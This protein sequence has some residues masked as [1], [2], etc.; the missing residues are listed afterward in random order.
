VSGKEAILAARNA[1]KKDIQMDVHRASVSLAG[2]RTWRQSKG[3]GDK[4]EFDSPSEASTYLLLCPFLSFLSFFSFFLYSFF[5]IIVSSFFHCVSSFSSFVLSFCFIFLFFLV[6]FGF[7]SSLLS[8]YLVVILIFPQPRS[9][10]SASLCFLSALLGLG[11][12]SLLAQ[13]LQGCDQTR[14]QKATL[15]Q[16]HVKLM[17]VW[18]NTYTYHF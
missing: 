12:F 4:Q 8:F 14:A 15:A 11:V 9:L 7:I 10:L 6:S 18:M 2:A 16:D 3:L 5:S 17:W 13:S 1:T